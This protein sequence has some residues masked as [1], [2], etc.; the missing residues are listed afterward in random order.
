LDKAMS[1][2]SKQTQVQKDQCKLKTMTLSTLLSLFT[3]MASFHKKCKSKCCDAYATSAPQTM[4]A[5]LS[6]KRIGLLLQT[7]VV[8]RIVLESQSTLSS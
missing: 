5:S 6:A 7:V 8:E 2:P 1:V 4:A 3:T